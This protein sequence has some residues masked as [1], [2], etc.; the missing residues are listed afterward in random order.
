MAD[1]I[2]T[3]CTNV[4]DEIGVETPSSIVGSSAN[5][6][7]RLFQAAKQTANELASRVDWA[8]LQKEHT[9]PTVAAQAAYD[10]PG[11]YDRM[12]PYT[13]WDRNNQW[14]LLGPFSPQD[15]QW[16]ESGIVQKGPRRRFRLKPDS[17]TKKFYVSPTPSSAGETLV[18]E[19]IS[20][21]W[22]RNNGGTAQGSIQNDTDT[23][24]FP[25]YLFR[26]GVLWRFQRA[27]GMPYLD[28]R[29]D[30][31]RELVREQANNSGMPRLS[32]N[33]RDTVILTANIQDA[34]FPSS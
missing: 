9:F 25:D 32:M 7:K 6:A 8:V 5:T 4:A 18:F 31:E 29:N 10:L 12:L 3:H 26:L 20:N 23:V 24:I 34:N 16:I 22:A 33:R 11:D 28:E 21:E 2:L 14:R 19:Y 13:H 17:G 30:F 27:L 15:W 1:S